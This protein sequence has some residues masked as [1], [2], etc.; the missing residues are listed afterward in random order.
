[1]G[2]ICFKQE[3]GQATSLAQGQCKKGMQSQDLNQLV[4][5][6]ALF[7]LLWMGFLLLS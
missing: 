7:V 3:E 4:L 5:S 1:V 2:D 6:A